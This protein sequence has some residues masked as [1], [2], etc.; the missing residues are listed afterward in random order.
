M[1]VV[2]IILLTAYFL[3]CVYASVAAMLNKRLK[4]SLRLA[5]LLRTLSGGVV[6]ACA[7]LYFFVHINEEKFTYTYVNGRIKEYSSYGRFEPL[8]FILTFLAAGLI[9]ISAF[10]DKKASVSGKTRVRNV[11][12]SVIMVFSVLVIGLIIIVSNYSGNLYDYQPRYFR[13]NSPDKSVS[14]VI[15]ERSWG[16]NG[17]GDIYQIKGEKAVKI[18]EFTTAGAFRNNGKYTLQW[19]STQ[20]KVT[21]L[22]KNGVHKTSSAP[23]AKL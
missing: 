10:V 21:Y 5:A 11:I 6:L 20:L 1:A 4:K 3:Y 18:G 9:I 15:C 23:F 8:F 13:F 14:I 12:V 7:L 19:S 2:I 16:E 17:Y 22:Y